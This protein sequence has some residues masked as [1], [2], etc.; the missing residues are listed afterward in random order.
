MRVFPNPPPIP[1]SLLQHSPTLGHQTSTGPW[2]SPRTDVRQGHPLLLK[3]LEPWILHYTLLGWWYCPW[4][5][6]VVQSANIVLSMVLHSPLLP[7]S[8][9][10]L[11]HQDGWLQ[12]STSA[13]VRCWQ[14]LP[15]NSHNRFLSA[16]T[17]CQQQ[18]RG[19]V[20]ADRM[21]P[22]VGRSPLGP[23]F[24]LCS[25]FCPSLS[26]GQ[27]HGS[28]I[29]GKGEDSRTQ[30]VAR[31]E[32]CRVDRACRDHFVLIG[33]DHSRGMGP[34]THLKVFTTSLKAP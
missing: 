14:K 30:N 33:T 1:A 27:E 26:F 20:S 22:Q 21:N 29:P 8:F 15:G 12:A 19:L 24:S 17:S 10:Q 13:L 9:C 4:E 2:A 23:Y 11:S 28:Q 5:H 3:Y 16:S 6:W 32:Q 34:P 7:Y 18:S 25:T 31:N